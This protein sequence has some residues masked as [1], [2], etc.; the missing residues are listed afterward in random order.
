MEDIFHMPQIVP[1]NLAYAPLL[2]QPGL[3]PIFFSNWRTLSCEMD[4]VTPN[5]TSL[6]AI[7]CKVHRARPVG[8]SEQAIS[9]TLAC[10]RLSNLS[11]RPLR[12]PSSRTSSSRVRGFFL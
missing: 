7:R 2:R 1:G 12:G 8:G 10:T 4:S 11:G 6:S 3:E 9:V 5:V